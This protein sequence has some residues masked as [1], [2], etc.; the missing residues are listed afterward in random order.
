MD[1]V[2][3]GNSRAQ[4]GAGQQPEGYRARPELKTWGRTGD[5]LGRPRATLGASGAWGTGCGVCITVR[6]TGLCAT[7][8]ELSWVLAVSVPRTPLLW[9]LVGAH[10]TQWGLKE[11]TS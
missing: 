4:A 7:E 9:S 3:A 1:Q 2:R 6:V 5:V 10:Q 11:A 8:P